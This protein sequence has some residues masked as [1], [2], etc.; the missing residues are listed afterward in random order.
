[1]TQLKNLFSPIKIGSMELKNRIVMTCANASGGGGEHVLQY[2][3]ERARGGCGLLIVGGMYTYD[4]GT[5][6]TFYGGRKDVTP[7]ED[8][9]IREFAL[10]GEEL[11]PFLQKFTDTMHEGGAKVCAQVS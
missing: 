2:Y 10:Y 11:L 1:M 7:E 3:A 4:T 8:R 9:A 5:G 6:K